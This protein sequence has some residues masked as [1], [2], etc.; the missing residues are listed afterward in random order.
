MISINNNFIILETKNTALIFEI[1]SFDTTVSPYILGKFYLSVFYYG[2]KKEDYGLIPSKQ[3]V[4]FSGSC[5]DYNYDLITNNTFGNCCN[6]EG[7]VLLDNVDGTNVNRFFYKSAKIVKEIG[8]IKG[9]HTRK[10]AEIIEIFEEDEEAGIKLSTYYSLFEDSDVI[11]V[12]RKIV[13]E[14]K[15]S[16]NIK[17]IASLDIQLPSKEVRISS[18]DG[19]WLRERYRHQ[20]TLTGGIFVNESLLFSSSHKHN[21]FIQIENLTNNDV[22]SFNLIWSCNFREYIDL[23]W[24][25]ENLTVQAGIN[26][27]L[28][29]YELKSNESFITPEAIMLVSSSLEESSK[30]MRHF[31][32]NHIV[33]PKW[34]KERPILFNSWEGSAFKIDENNLLQ[35]ADRCKQVG[36]E[37]FV[38]DDGWFLGRTTEWQALGDWVVDKNKFPQGFKHCAD[39]IKSR[40]LKFGFWIEPEMISMVSEIYKKHPEFACKLPNREPLERRHQLMIDMSNPAVINYLFECLSKVIDEV[41]PSYIKWDFNRNMSDA[42]SYSNFKSGEFMYKYMMGSYDLMERL[43]KAYPDVMFEGCSSGGG[44]FDLGICYYMPQSWGSDNSN[45]YFRSFISCGTFAGYPVSTFGAHVSRDHYKVNGVNMAASL[46]D[47]FNLQAFGGFGYEFNLCNLSEHDLGIVK[48]QVEYYKKHRLLIQFGDLEIVDN[49]FDNND[50]CS[51]QVSSKDGS[52]IM[53]TIIQTNP[54]AKGRAWK[55]KNLDKNAIY[56]IEMR[57]QDN[58]SKK[59]PIKDSY[60]GAA[61]MEQGIKLDSMYDTDDKESFVGIFSRMFYLKKH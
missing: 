13:N 17:N 20:T 50:Y 41:E 61:L 7:S 1:K 57:K 34:L 2:K 49:I 5:N 18:Y 33:D 40:G 60:T 36:I 14:N 51:Y 21:P 47:R 30:E 58:L 12:R 25:K 9:P 27:Y 10:V 15:K 4:S 6:V 48:K 31:V 23:D 53:F 44:R 35:M 56:S 55:M 46:E 45:S 26:P 43:T 42:Y 19:A 32:N 37:L 54:S 8:G 24:V 28:F 16:V 11:S 59:M 39:E 38:I 22:Y 29:S 52:E 3:K